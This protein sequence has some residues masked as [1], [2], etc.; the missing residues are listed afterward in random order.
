MRVVL[1]LATAVAA[2]MTVGA[3][4][5]GDGAALVWTGPAAIVAGLLF[6]RNLRDPAITRK[7]GLRARVAFTFSPPAGVTDGGT[8]AVVRTHAGTWH[9][10]LDRVPERADMALDGVDQ[11]GRVWL[12]ESGLPARVRIEYGT[13]WKTWTVVSA[14]ETTDEQGD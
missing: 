11:R 9:V 12:V 7:G 6:R 4:A 1:F 13:A 5:N 3:I 14:V 10:S 8:Y 2:I